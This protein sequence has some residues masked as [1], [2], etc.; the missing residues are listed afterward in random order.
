MSDSG[1][2]S[3]SGVTLPSSSTLWTYWVWDAR[4]L[5]ERGEIRLALPASTSTSSSL[6]KVRGFLMIASM[7]S[8]P[9]SSSSMNEGSMDLASRRDFWAR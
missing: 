9:F 1:T 2:I 6:M 5:I 7:A 4:W 8:N 3:F